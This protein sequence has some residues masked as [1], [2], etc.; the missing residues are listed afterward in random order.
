[1]R[2]FA[3]HR[4]FSSRLAP[5]VALLTFATPGAALAFE[6]RFPGGQY[7]RFEGG[8]QDYHVLKVDLCAPG[9][10]FRGTKPGERAQVVSSFGGSVGAA[11]AINGDFFNG[12]YE[13]MGPAMGDGELWGGGDHEFI[14]PVTFG[15]RFVEVPHENVVG[16]PPGAQQAVCGRPTLLDDGNLVGDNGDGLCT[17]RHPR[18]AIGISQDHRTMILVVVDGR[19]GGAAGMTCD[20]LAGVL[21]D[22]GA[23]DAVNVDGGGSS[24]MWLGNGG[25]V[26]RP[27]DGRE[28]TVANHLAIIAPGSGD[29]A[30]CPEPAYRAEIVGTGGFSPAADGVIEIGLGRAAVGFVELRN[31]GRAGWDANT[32]L[33]P[34]PRDQPSVLGAPSWLSPTRVSSVTAA[35]PPGEVG[36]FALPLYGNVLGESTQTFA[37]VQEGAAWFADQ[38]GPADDALSVRARVVEAPAGPPTSP[39]DGEA[40]ADAAEVIWRTEDA[41]VSVPE[42]DAV[43]PGPAP[44]GGTAG[45]GDPGAGGQALDDDGADAGYTAVETGPGG[46]GCAVAPG[47]AGRGA[48]TLGGVFWLAG[49]VGLVGLAGLR[50]RRR[51]LRFVRDRRSPGTV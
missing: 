31:T 28:R 36:R 6:E 27:S 25:V 16:L 4:S 2:P 21:R 7:Q 24:T 32:K 23:F 5:A 48:G 3:P 19:R 1:M 39:P 18:T 13:T 34:T 49:L 43:G 22:H 20:E 17:A 44:T 10:R 33:A 26:N 47:V 8:G 9:I 40:E 51:A 42:S 37:L 15:P 35:T 11:A 38:G 12:S 50:G 41:F 14:A 30:H 29:A 45:G 46:G